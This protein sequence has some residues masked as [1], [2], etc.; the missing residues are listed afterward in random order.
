M[1]I[2][3]L[4]AR[5]SCL[6]GEESVN[7]SNLSLFMIHFPAISGIMSRDSC[8]HVAMM[9][10]EWI[11][12]AEF[13]VHILQ[14][15]LIIILPSPMA[16]SVALRTWEQLVRSPARPILMI[17]IATGFIPLSPLSVVL[18]MVTW[19]SSQWLGKNI[20]RNT[21]WKNSRKAWIGALVA[22]I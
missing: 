10:T 1:S 2:K 21:G 6:Q 12:Y 14:P 19:D 13:W 8:V 16:Q 22:V 9:Y 18:P 3:L 4:A 15:F 17:V 20:V 5:V 7:E 11:I